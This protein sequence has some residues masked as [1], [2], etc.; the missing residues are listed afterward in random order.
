MACRLF[1][2]SDDDLLLT[3]P[4][5]R[6]FSEILIKIQQFSFKKISLK[7]SPKWKSFCFGL[8][9]NDRIAFCHPI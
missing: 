3:E 2:W 7:M 8:S 5:G 6:N 1:I 9:V 4:M